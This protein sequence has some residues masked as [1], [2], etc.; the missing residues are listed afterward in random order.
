MNPTRTVSFSP[1]VIG[2]I[3]D[4]IFCASAM[5]L[6]LF[7]HF[8]LVNVADTDP[9][10]HYTHAYLYRHNG[11]LF[12]SF[13]WASAS[14]ISHKPGDLWYGFHLLLAPFAQNLSDVVAMK[15]AA[16]FVIAL[17]MALL[18]VALRLARVPY[19]YV[20]PFLVVFASGDEMA[21]LMMLRPQ[22]ISIG[23]AAIIVVAVVQKRPGIAGIASALMLWIHL[24]MIWLL[25]TAVV[26]TLTALAIA[27]ER[28]SA[29]VLAAVVLGA[30][31]GWVARPHPWWTL[32]LL[33]VQLVQLYRVKASGI[34]LD[35]GT[36]LYPMKASPFLAMYAP[37]AVIWI[38]ALVALA[39]TARGW[40]RELDGKCRAFLLANIGL[41][42]FFFGLMFASASRSKDQWTA[43]AVLALASTFGT[44]AL[45]AIRQRRTWP[46]LGTA[47]AVGLSL[48][49]A[50]LGAVALPVNE[51]LIAE[52][53][54]PYRF[55]APC[56]WLREN[57]KPGDIV[58][59][60]LWTYFSEMFFWNP[61]NRYIGAMDPIFE[62][63]QDHRKFW[64]WE[65]FANPAVNSYVVDAP[66]HAHGRHIDVYTALTRDF[67]A[68][69]IVVFHQIEPHLYVRLIHDPRFRLG[70]DDGGL[71]IFA[72][73]R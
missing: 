45:P 56:K 46:S 17:S 59:C 8:R 61:Q 57:S 2:L 32:E 11:P 9:F 44:V 72:I 60:G 54:S 12:A 26:A 4:L 40:W 14:I 28:V 41:S 48:V 36:E 70:Y 73:A 43:F 39:A 16:A 55:Q 21:R 27:R 15:F 52:N 31:V 69:Y 67:D 63:A 51:K 62:Y 5:A 30:V 29:R 34:D 3:K 19:P 42:V 35:W 38:G 1:T 22:E 24:N 64:E 49:T 71:A 37:F 7:L 18:L 33:N 23:F 68:R 25:A 13:P 20:W 47:V 65:S 66:F 58:F 10:Y 6:A 53:F 50:G